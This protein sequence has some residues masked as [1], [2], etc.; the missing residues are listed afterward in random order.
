MKMIRPT[1]SIKAPH[2]I[3][4]RQ[5]TTHTVISLPTTPDAMIALGVALLAFGAVF[6]LLKPD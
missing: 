2:G 6:K 4:V 5:T 3:A 1:R